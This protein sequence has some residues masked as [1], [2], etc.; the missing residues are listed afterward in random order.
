MEENNVRYIYHEGQKSRLNIRKH[1]IG[2][3]FVI[4]LNII[5]LK[6]LHEKWIIELYLTYSIYFSNI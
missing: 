3:V 1:F 6:V 2:V 5:H 4:K